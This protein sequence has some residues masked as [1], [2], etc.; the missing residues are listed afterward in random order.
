[1]KTLLIL[2]IVALATTVQ[3]QRPDCMGFPEYP[4]F[5]DNPISCRA[6]FTC[7][8]EGAEAIDNECPEPYNFNEEA[9]MCDSPINFPCEDTTPDPEDPPVTTTTPEPPTTTVRP[10]PPRN[11]CEGLPDGR[12][13][14]NPTGCRS[15]FE[16]R[17]EVALP[18]QCD[19]GLNF[20]EELQMCDRPTFTPCSNDDFECPYFGIS[21]WEVPGS[22]TEFNFCFAGQ[23]RVEECAPG[24]TFDTKLALCALQENVD[25][26]RDLC[27]IDN[28]IDNIVTHPSEFSCEEYYK[29]YDGIRELQY[30]AP[31]THWNQ[32]RQRCERPE[33]A[34]C[35]LPPDDT[36]TTTDPGVTDPIVEFECPPSDVILFLPHPLICQNYFVCIDEVPHERRCADRLL[37]D[38]LLLDCN[39]AE[40]TTCADGATREVTKK[41]NY[42]IDYIARRF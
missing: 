25:C 11:V 34:E 27:P 36:T 22:C 42:F 9:Q 32:E 2:W 26:T 29:C 20:N 1:M 39:I 35:S 6:Y 14:N 40:D 41:T 3:T 21:R 24:L 12:L 16:C 23:H 18:R 5:V 15:F 17:N 13:V 4:W 8:Y 33:D 7:A 10:P 31:G 37:F 19:M 28:D 38:A 30:C